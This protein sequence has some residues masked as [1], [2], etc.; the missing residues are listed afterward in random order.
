MPYFRRDFRPLQVN[1][2]CYKDKFETSVRMKR[3]NQN[4]EDKAETDLIDQFDG[5]NQSR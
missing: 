2:D 5:S 1:H 4:Y 3:K